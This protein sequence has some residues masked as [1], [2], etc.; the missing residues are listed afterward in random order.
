LLLCLFV[1]INRGLYRLPF[2][3]SNDWSNIETAFRFDLE[4][5]GSYIFSSVGTY[6]LLVEP[7]G[8]LGLGLMLGRKEIASSDEYIGE[9]TGIVK[10]YD[11][12]DTSNYNA[13]LVEGHYIIDA[14]DSSNILKYCNH[15]C[16]P[17]A[18]L[19]VCIHS[20]SG[21]LRVGMFSKYSIKPFSWIN[22][23]YCKGKTLKEFFKLKKCFCN[24]CVKTNK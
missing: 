14:K 16:K 17:N 19:K 9:Y 21:E 7:E 4:D 12:S 8:C 5:Y 20:P 23:C 13:T 2:F 24:S 1:K 18:Y 6:E 10:V 22:I 15:S 3:P 11:E